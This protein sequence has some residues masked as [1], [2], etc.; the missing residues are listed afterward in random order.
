MK[1]SGK[2]PSVRDAYVKQI[3]QQQKEDAAAK[4]G[5]KSVEK[6]DTIKISDE[7]RELQET[8]K[9]MENI[10]DVQVEKVAKLKNQI[11]N[12]TYDIKSGKIAEKMITDSVLNE[13]L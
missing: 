3:S 9:V 7:A 13:L 4:P 12:G 1:I 11:E 6:A 5:V 2:D 8:Q 10:P